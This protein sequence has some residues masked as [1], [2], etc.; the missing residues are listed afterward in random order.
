MHFYGLQISRDLMKLKGWIKFLGFKE[1]FKYLQLTFHNQCMSA[2]S[3][4]PTALSSHW[5]TSTDIVIGHAFC[6]RLGRRENANPFHSWRPGF[7]FINQ[8]IIGQ[9][10]WEENKTQS[11]SCVIATKLYFKLSD[12]FFCFFLPDDIAAKEVLT[13][14]QYKY[15]L[16]VYGLC[17]TA[18]WLFYANRVL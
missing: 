6:L 7:G 15:F 13:K 8:D 17:A 12:L 1:F 10:I 14:L 2:L 11:K 5:G 16:G 18:K 4:T 3:H 9:K